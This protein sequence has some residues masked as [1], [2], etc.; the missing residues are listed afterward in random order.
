M[1]Q[2]IL[3]FSVHLLVLL[4]VDEVIAKGQFITPKSDIARYSFADPTVRP[5]QNLSSLALPSRVI[6]IGDVHGSYQ[7]LQRLL[8]RVEYDPNE[9]W[10]VFTGD[11][12][13]R[14]PDSLKVL[15]WMKKNEAGC[16]RGNHD[17][18][19]VRWRVF[20]DGDAP[21]TNDNDE[22]DEDDVELVQVNQMYDDGVRRMIRRKVPRELR[23]RKQHRKLAE[24]LPRSLMRYL[25]RCPLILN[26][27]LIHV[28]HAGF[29]PW[30]PLAEQPTESLL[31]L[32]TILSDG[33]PIRAHHP[34]GR[35][36][37]HVWRDFQRQLRRQGDSGWRVVYGHDAGRGV[38]VDAWV[39]GLDGGCVRGG[40]L[41]A[42]VV[43]Y[44]SDF[45]EEIQ[46]VNED[47]KRR[48]M[49]RPSMGWI[50]TVKCKDLTSMD[51]EDDDFERYDVTMDAESDNMSY[52]VEEEEEEE[53]EEWR[54][55]TS[56]PAGFSS[57]LDTLDFNGKY[58]STTSTNGHI[59]LLSNEEESDDEK[60]WWWSEDGQFPSRQSNQPK[61]VIQNQPSSDAM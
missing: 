33:T 35:A 43:N 17:D 27:P 3:L 7:P 28:V 24:T 60:V 58:A 31:N 57:W 26:L 55:N 38:N 23:D 21:F 15:R 46:D 40:K 47:R 6:F 30:Y 11:M 5:Q 13:T 29:L 8:R 53:E 59:P 37:T 34:P 52:V 14:G 50:G 44:Q 9:D 51:V 22:D 2:K 10:V 56:T 1:L 25:A 32:R 16:V 4:C 61:L 41:A 48:R 20:L 36:W 49:K 12:V 19:V 42:L 45:P 54:F 18:L 39:A